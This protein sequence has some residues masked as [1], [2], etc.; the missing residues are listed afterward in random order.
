MV[1]LQQWT[2]SQSFCL[3]PASSSPPP[4]PSPSISLSHACLLLHL[5]SL[6]ALSKPGLTWL[7]LPLLLLQHHFIK[8]HLFEVVVIA[9]TVCVMKCSYFVGE[10]CCFPLRFY[11]DFQPHRMNE[12]TYSAGIF[13]VLLGVLNEHLCMRS[14]KSNMK[15]DY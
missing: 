3:M 10:Y 2:K 8:S 15:T 11:V 1:R 4:P 6:P 7:P 12:Q 14:C 9:L 5:T 13:L